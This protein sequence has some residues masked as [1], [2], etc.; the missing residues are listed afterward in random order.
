MK[1]RLHDE[2]RRTARR[3]KFESLDKN[4]PSDAPIP[5]AALLAAERHRRY[6]RALKALR[7]KD[8][9]LLNARVANE[10]SL[11]TI[12]ARFGLATTAAAGM[13]VRRAEQ[14]LRAQLGD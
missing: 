1:N 14:R 5:L 2:F 3:P 8:Q 7:R 10:D 9:Q 6:Q 11:A 13:A 12:A 4:A